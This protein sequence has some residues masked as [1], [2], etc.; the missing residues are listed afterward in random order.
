MTGSSGVASASWDH[1]LGGDRPRI[2][3]CSVGADS[4]A[5]DAGPVLDWSPDFESIPAEDDDVTARKED[6]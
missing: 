3:D 4:T 1:Q 5:V 6:A 2:P